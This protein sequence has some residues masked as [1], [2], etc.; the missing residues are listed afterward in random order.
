MLVVAASAALAI[1]SLAW[2]RWITQGRGMEPIWMGG[3][4]AGIGLGWLLAWAVHREGRRKP[5]SVTL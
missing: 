2:G 5:G 4:W 3:V 1:G